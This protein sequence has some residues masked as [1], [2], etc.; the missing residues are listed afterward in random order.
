M[1]TP[2]LSIQLFCLFIEFQQILLE[3]KKR[4]TLKLS[5]PK[6]STIPNDL[7]QVD[8]LFPKVS[9]NISPETF[10]ILISYFPLFIL[11]CYAKVCKIL[12]KT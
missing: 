2:S 1:I 12:F 7:L 11:K 9:K 3:F 10:F 8:M 4:H 6:M 5:L